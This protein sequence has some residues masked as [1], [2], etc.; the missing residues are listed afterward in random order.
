MAS[1]LPEYTWSGVVW[2]AKTKSPHSWP[3]MR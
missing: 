1:Q 2:N 3:R